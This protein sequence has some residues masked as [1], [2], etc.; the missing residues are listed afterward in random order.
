MPLCWGGK[1]G[2]RELDVDSSFSKGGKKMGDKRALLVGIDEYKH[3]PA[4]TGCVAD[5]LAMA[6]L[7]RRN[8]NRSL[9]YHCR[10][11]T[12]AEKPLITKERLRSEWNAL[13]DNFD[14]HIL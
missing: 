7:L 4:L 2:T 12:S 5:A 8:E 10:V 13:F 11:L 14:G 6:D 1:M 9:N 3:M